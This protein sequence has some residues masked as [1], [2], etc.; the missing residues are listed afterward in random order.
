MINIYKS[1][2]FILLLYHNVILLLSVIAIDETIVK[3]S[4]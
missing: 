4:H 3:C 1:D 2:Y